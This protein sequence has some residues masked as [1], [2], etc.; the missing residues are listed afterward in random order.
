MEGTVLEPPSPSV[1]APSAFSGGSVC[2]ALLLAALAVAALLAARRRRATPRLLQIVE[3]A[4]LGP[5][6]SLVLARVGGELLL[7]GSSEGGVS[8][9]SRQSAPAEPARG[10]IAPVASPAGAPVARTARLELVLADG[11][12]GESAEHVEL[13]RKLAAGQVGSIR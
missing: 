10:A 5:K 8:L 6:R 2:A 11:A 1:P 9:L 3:S 13:R 12:P 7:L 4:S